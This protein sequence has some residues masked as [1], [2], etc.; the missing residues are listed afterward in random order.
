[1]RSSIE[2]SEEVLGSTGHYEEVYPRRSKSK[3]PSPLKV[4][5]V[6]INNRRYVICLN[7]EQARKDKHDRQAIVASLEDAL[8]RGDKTLIGNKGYRKFV[9]A[10][11]EKFSID[12][13]K[14][15]EEERYDGKWVITTNTSLSAKEAA[16]KYKQLWTVED[17]FRSMKSL[18]ETRPIYH[19]CDETI[20]G[21]VFCSFLALVLRKELQDRLEEKGYELEWHD[22]I[23]DLDN[24]LEMQISI[25]NKSYVVRS[26][27]T[28]TVGKVVQACTVSPPQIL[29]K[30]IQEDVKN[31]SYGTT[32]V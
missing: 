26:E 11:S 13:D 28:N 6:V 22:V 30:A 29:R 2:V 15:K 20:R 1:M 14:I 24:L 27:T 3:D 9:K 10:G 18:L 16:L 23:N 5:E 32:R 17:I 8:S 12:T 19:K 4:K 25:D 21:H 7:E 31:E